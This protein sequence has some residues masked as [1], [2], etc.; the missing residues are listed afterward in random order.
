MQ[1]AQ[2]SSAIGQPMRSPRETRCSRWLNAAAPS[3][4]VSSAPAERVRRGFLPPVTPGNSVPWSDPSPRPTPTNTTESRKNG[5]AAGRAARYKE[6]DGQG[7]TGSENAWTATCWGT[8]AMHRTATRIDYE[9]RV[10]RVLVHL[11]H[12]LD[13]A[14]DLNELA[15]IASFSPYHFHRVFRGLVGES[16]GEHVRRLRL[17]RAAWQLKRGAE[18]I[19]NV[20]LAAGYESHE[21]FTRAFRSRFGTSP[22]DYRRETAAGVASAEDAH[23]PQAVLTEQRRRTMNETLEARIEEREPV[24]VAFARHVGPYA[25]VGGAW[26]RLMMWAGPR[27]LCGPSMRTF[28]MCHDDPEVTPPERL[29]YDACIVVGAD[30]Q[31]DG[32]VGAQNIAGGDYAIARHAGPYTSLSETYAALMGRWIPEQG[33]TMANGPCLE[34]YLNDPRSTPP[35]QLLTDVCVPLEPAV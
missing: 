17:E 24:R 16:V 20:A 1:P 35:E 22:S 2:A 23:D 13:S 11:Q 14:P 3:Y 27:G 34:V 6:R 7:R 29:R 26:Q 33:R 32:D 18:S 25:E 21:A 28:G 5:Q 10:L 31:G 9:H 30:F 8:A 4:V 15:R 12:Q 19:L